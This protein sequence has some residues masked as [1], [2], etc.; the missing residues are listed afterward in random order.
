MVGV[1]S[2][3]LGN[4]TDVAV[5]ATGADQPISSESYSMERPLPKTKAIEPTRGE[6]IGIDPRSTSI[7]IG[8][9]SDETNEYNDAVTSEPIKSVRRSRSDSKPEFDSQS[10][11]PDRILLLTEVLDQESDLGDEI[12][13]KSVS[14]FESVEETMNCP[15]TRKRDSD[16]NN[17]SDEGVITT[18][19][20]GASSP[21]NSKVSNRQL[22]M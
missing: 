12:K 1:R 2:T 14:Q 20:T 21:L 6:Q 4:G 16:N 17:Y 11:D 3:G 8:V 7:Q 10:L 5:A 22:P 13:K 19:I 9:I 15:S 18:V